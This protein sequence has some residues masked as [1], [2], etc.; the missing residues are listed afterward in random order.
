[1]SINAW[2]DIEKMKDP[3]AMFDLIISGIYFAAQFGNPIPVDESRIVFKK[4]KKLLKHPKE[5]NK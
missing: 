4:I 3:D 2:K 5:S 1:M